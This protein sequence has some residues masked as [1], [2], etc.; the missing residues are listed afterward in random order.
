MKRIPLTQGKFALVDDEDFEYLNQWKWHTQRGENGNYYAARKGGDRV[1]KRIHTEIF[2]VS[3]GNLVDHIDGNGFNN[4]KENLREATRSQNAHNSKR[5]ITNTSGFKGVYLSANKAN[6]WRATIKF[7][8]KFYRL[9]YFK[10]AEEAHI[11]W[12]KAAI[13]LHGAFARW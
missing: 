11:A 3:P 9:G 8:G 4:Q 12:K 1:H 10:T 7:Q 6:P 5:P 2:K 13:L